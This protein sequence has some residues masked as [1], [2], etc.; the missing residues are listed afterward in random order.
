[1]FGLGVK[2]E[3]WF[4]TSWRAFDLRQPC[5]HPEPVVGVYGYSGPRPGSGVLSGRLRTWSRAMNIDWMTTLELAQAIPP[6]YTEY[7]GAAL[8]EH[9]AAESVS[10]CET[11]GGNRLPDRPPAG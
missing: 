6:A 11:A 4:E 3:R 2:R 1:M 8:L 10:G 7:I 5:S 9:L